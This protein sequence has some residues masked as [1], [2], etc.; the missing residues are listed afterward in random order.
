[1]KLT[2]SSKTATEFLDLTKFKDVQD[3]SKAN[4]SLVQKYCRLY[5]DYIV[6]NNKL[7]VAHRDMITR[8]ALGQSDKTKDIQSTPPQSIKFPGPVRRIFRLIQRVDPDPDSNQETNDNSQLFAL[9]GF[10][11]IYKVTGTKNQQ[12][13]KWQKCR[14]GFDEEHIV[15][16]IEQNQMA[17]THFFVG[18]YHAA[19][20]TSGP[21]L[22]HPENINRITGKTD[23][24]TQLR[25]HIKKENPKGALHLQSSST[26]E[27]YDIYAVVMGETSLLHGQKIFSNAQYKICEQPTFCNINKEIG[28]KSFDFCLLRTAEKTIRIP[29]PEI[30]HTKEGFAQPYAREQEEKE[31]HQKIQ[32]YDHLKSL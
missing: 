27:L 6:R 20:S 5:T 7:Y 16:C 17:D 10:K 25:K 14:M 24:R 18:C 4:H 26:P 1:M 8:F 29:M 9:V 31:P 2:W 30:K 23:M 28:D 3:V 21:M 22:V 13:D 32:V 15:D 11:D 19:Q 12:G